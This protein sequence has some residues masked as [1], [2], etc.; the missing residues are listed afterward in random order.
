[1]LSE[2]LFNHFLNSFCLSSVCAIVIYL[3]IINHFLSEIRSNIND[4]ILFAIPSNHESILLTH[5]TRDHTII[6]KKLLFNNKF[7]IRSTAVTTYIY[8]Y[9]QRKSSISSTIP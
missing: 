2:K 4:P 7:E 6:I 5:T 1:M 3:E 9:I 8:L